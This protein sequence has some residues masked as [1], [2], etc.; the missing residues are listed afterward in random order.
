VLADKN[1]LAAANAWIPAEQAKFTE[2]IGDRL[3]VY[4]MDFDGV[5]DIDCGE[6]SEKQPVYAANAGQ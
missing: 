5:V 4:E 3:V 2:Q 1:R 6:F